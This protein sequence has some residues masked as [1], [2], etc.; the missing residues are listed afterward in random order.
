MNVEYYTIFSRLFEALDLEVETLGAIVDWIDENNFE[1]TGGAEKQHYESLSPPRK[2]K[3]APLYS[4]S[5]AAVIKGFQRR[6]IY[7]PRVPVDFEENQKGLAGVSDLEKQL[8]QKEDWVLSNNVTVY[9]PHTLLGTEKVSINAAR[10]HVLLSLSEAMGRQEILSIFKLKGKGG[11]YIKSQKEVEAIPELQRPS[12]TGALADVT[13]A[14]ELFG[15]GT[16]SGTLKMKSRFYRVT[17]IGFIAVGS[18]TKEKSLAVRRVWG[19]WD[20]DRREFIYYS[21]D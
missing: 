19:I 3:N 2:I 12:G 14:K 7:D 6:L 9:L 13:L 15:V 8:L 21:E 11:G 4:L 16:V 17:G 10:Y 1:S 5:E 18:D 20:K